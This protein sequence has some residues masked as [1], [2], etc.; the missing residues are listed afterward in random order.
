M[1]LDPTLAVYTQTR[2]WENTG[3]SDLGMTKVRVNGL[4]FETEP[5]G[6]IFGSEQARVFP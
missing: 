1:V 4:N 6:N 3:W 5:S 2:P